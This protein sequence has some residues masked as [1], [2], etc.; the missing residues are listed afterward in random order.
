[1]K[2]NHGCERKQGGYFE[3]MKENGGNGVIMITR[4]NF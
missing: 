2:R 3:E 4:N 1:M